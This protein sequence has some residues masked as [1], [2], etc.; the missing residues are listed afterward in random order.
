M[1]SISERCSCGSTVSVADVPFADAKRFVREW[2]RN[3]ECS[4]AEPEVSMVASTTNAVVELSGNVMGFM[5]RPF[6]E[7]DD[8]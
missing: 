3:H 1:F 5:A 2:R 8:E 4:V 6:S 7:E